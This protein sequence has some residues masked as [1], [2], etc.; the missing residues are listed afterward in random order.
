MISAMT[1]LLCSKCC[2]NYSRAKTVCGN[3]VVE[4]PRIPKYCKDYLN[5]NYSQCFIVDQIYLELFKFVL[6]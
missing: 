2:G 3:T 6:A 4:A 1:L 5:C